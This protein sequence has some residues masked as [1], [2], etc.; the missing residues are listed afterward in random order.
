MPTIFLIAQG[1]V[2]TRSLS[3]GAHSRDPLA[4]PTLRFRYFPIFSHSQ[5][6]TASGDDAPSP[7]AARRLASRMAAMSI[8][9]SS[10]ASAA[11][12]LCVVGAL[13]RQQHDGVIGRDRVPGVVQ[14]DQ[15]V[16]RD[17]PVAGV[18]RDDVDLAGGDGGIHEIRLHLRAGVRNVSP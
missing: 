1:M 8:L 2:G 9:P 12:K 7:P 13:R 3:S 18:A 17:Q 6:A 11:R 5:R 16:F 15:I 14:H 10:G 4:L